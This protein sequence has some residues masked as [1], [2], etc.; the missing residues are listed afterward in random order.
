MASLHPTMG[1]IRGLGLMIGVEFVE[2]KGSK[3]PIK[4]K[5]K[6]FAAAF[7]H[8][9]VERGMII[10]AMSGNNIKAQAGDL[11]LWGP[12]YVTSTE[13]YNKMLQI[14]DECLAQTEKEFG[15]K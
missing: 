13:D 7:G 3:Q 5:D 4:K 15:F 12:Q 2:D 8:N 11:A 14:F 9:C 6:S 1:D 10:E